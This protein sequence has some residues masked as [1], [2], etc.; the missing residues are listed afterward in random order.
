MAIAYAK[1]QKPGQMNLT[2]GTF[3]KNSVEVAKRF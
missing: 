1:A 3:I 2:W